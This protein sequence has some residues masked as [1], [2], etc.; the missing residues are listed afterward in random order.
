MQFNKIFND[1]KLGIIKGI[2]L[3]TLPPKID[4]IYNLFYIRAFRVIGGICFIFSI[5]NNIGLITDNLIIKII[6]TI[7]GLIFI[8]GFSIINIIIIITIKK[9]LQEDKYEIKNT[10]KNKEELKNFVKKITKNYENS[11]NK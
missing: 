7:I 2:S 6:C 9:I 10:I 8:M 3:S 4:K 5:I 1:I 11:K